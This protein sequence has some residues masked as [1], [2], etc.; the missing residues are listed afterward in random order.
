MKNRY[1][2]L[3][4][5]LKCFLAQNINVG[6]DCEKHI[7]MLTYYISGQ[8]FE[9]IH[10]FE[11]LQM[12]SSQRNCLLPGQA[13]NVLQRICTYNVL[14]LW[15]YCRK[16]IL[17]P[18]NYVKVT[19]YG[20]IREISAKLWRIKS[21]I[22]NSVCNQVTFKPSSFLLFAQRIC[23]SEVKLLSLWTHY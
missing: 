7:I 8:L 13:Q 10:L 20:H 18:E 22:V 14:L 16:F 11:R 15:F 17:M 19:M 9:H 5:I 23:A 2:S 1:F 3:R 6:I 21:S 4:H 12:L